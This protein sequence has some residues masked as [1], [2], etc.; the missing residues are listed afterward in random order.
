MLRWDPVRLQREAGARRGNQG[1]GTSGG[2]FSTPL[3]QAGTTA[4]SHRVTRDTEAAQP[5]SHERTEG[6]TAPGRGTWYP[7]RSRH[8]LCSGASFGRGLW[9]TPADG[10]S[11]LLP[12]I[13]RST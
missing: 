7:E 10:A 4:G 11:P 3:L 13:S 6:L 12:Q 8:Q 5:Q 9:E 1:E 2:V